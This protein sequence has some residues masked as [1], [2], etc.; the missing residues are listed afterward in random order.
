MDKSWIN[1]IELISDGYCEKLCST[2]AEMRE[3]DTIYPP[4]EKLLYALELVPFDKVKVVILGQ[5]P[6]HGEN[7]SHGLAFSVTDGVPVPPSLRN[8]FKELQDDTE[9]SQ[10]S[11]GSD[12]F[13][14]SAD[15]SPHPS[16]TDL[17]RWAKQGVLLLNATLSVSAS[18]PK[19]HSELGWQKLTDQI[20]E[21][22][23][24]KREHLVF[25]LWGN[26]ARKKKKLIN[27]EKHLILEAAHPS[28]LSAYRG[29]F[30]CRHFS[31]TNSYLK[32]HGL[33]PIYW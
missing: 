4:Q 14:L 15:D 12:E 32:Q 25:I 29:F 23:S 31:K 1:N 16:S 13:F 24:R 17:T 5:D 9:A 28:P 22:L 33:T 3:S 10:V 19:S 11:D 20:I 18:K 6:Y 26:D 21:Q 8:I 7:Q 2:V 27:S 30:G